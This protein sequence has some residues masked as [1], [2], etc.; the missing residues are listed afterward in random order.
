M[1]S[2]ER[3]PAQRRASRRLDPGEIHGKN[4]KVRHFVPILIVLKNF[5]SIDGQLVANMG[6][7][8][9]A[10]YLDRAGS[11]PIACVLNLT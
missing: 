5:Q 3:D 9:Q 1:A 6:A 8:F 11:L 7:S 4:G 2:P 10:E